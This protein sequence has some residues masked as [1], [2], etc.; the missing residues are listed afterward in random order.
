[1]NM[2]QNSHNTHQKVGDK[3]I[4]VVGVKYEKKIDIEKKSG[5]ALPSAQ[6]IMM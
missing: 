1:M 4:S 6:V 5:K 3:N 2:G